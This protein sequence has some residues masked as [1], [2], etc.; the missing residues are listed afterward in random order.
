[1]MFSTSK[2]AHIDLLHGIGQCEDR[3]RPHRNNGASDA[4]S[5]RGFKLDGIFFVGPR[6]LTQLQTRLFFLGAVIHPRE[7][8]RLN[9]MRAL[10][11][12]SKQ[13]VTSEMGVLATAEY[14]ADRRYAGAR[15][16]GF[17]V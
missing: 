10:V 7:V 16:Q 14:G 17:R 5:P 2:L 9:V 6:R 4:T 13:T 15:E 8:C 3:R 1:M 11:N 12:Q